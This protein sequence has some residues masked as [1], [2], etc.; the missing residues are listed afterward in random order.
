M[1]VQAL[2]SNGILIGRLVADG[3]YVYIRALGV[4]GLLRAV[5]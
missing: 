3:I 1:C 2:N 5:A 4:N